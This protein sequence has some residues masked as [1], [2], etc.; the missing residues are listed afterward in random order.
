MAIV[1]IMSAMDQQD[2]LRGEV[3]TALVKMGS[4][5]L[6]GNDLSAFIKRAG[7]QVADAMQR[8]TFHSGE[9]PV[10]S[11][12]LGSG[13]FYGMN[14][15]GDYFPEEACRKYHKTFEKYARAYRDHE[16]KDPA[17]S[18]GIVK[19]AFYNDPM[20]RIELI[21]ALN[22]TKEAA[23]RNGGLVADQELEILNRGGDYDTSM[24]CKVPYDICSGC[25]NRAR[26]RKE[27]CTSE[28][29]GGHCKYGGLMNNITLMT[30][31][32]KPLYAINDHPL[33]FDNSKVWR[34]A[35]RIAM[36][37]LLKAASAISLGGAALAEQMGVTMPWGIALLKP[38]GAQPYLVKLAGKLA[39]IEEDLQKN[40]PR[41]TL[42]LA[43]AGEDGRS[44]T[45]SDHGGTFTQ[46]LAGLA[47]EKVALPLSGF[48]E[49]ATGS[50]EKAAS[51]LDVVRSRLPGVYT[52]MVSD[53]SIEQLTA[54]NPFAVSGHTAVPIRVREWAQKRAT[55]HGLD[56]AVLLK[57][58]MRAS[59]YERTP[60]LREPGLEKVAGAAEELARSY[61]VYKLAFLKTVA[62][63][64]RDFDYTCAMVVRQNY[65]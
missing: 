38:D 20:H 2:M 65:V 40:P 59:L 53:G 16:N 47:R 50:R 64:D 56:R 29:E 63:H 13:E 49:L 42:H 44:T 7:H 6:R 37:G 46:A 35:D 58:A 28:A 41:D 19:L 51:H 30:K 24:A 18:Y 60:V 34:H 52:R 36:A 55:D 27:Y 48:L 9:V 61:A 62:D 31:E 54:E 43:F 12:A 26:T 15:N 23:A 11:I 39:Q 1:K 17:K 33:W 10:H 5:G 3:P 25:G 32:G 45:W 14:R 4:A 57:R 8:L 21:H 22:G